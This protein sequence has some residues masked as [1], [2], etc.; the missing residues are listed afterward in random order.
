MAVGSGR[1]GGWDWGAEVGEGAVTFGVA[2]VVIAI[3]D[4][5]LSVRLSA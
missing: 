4:N 5:G 3:E 2:G 1:V